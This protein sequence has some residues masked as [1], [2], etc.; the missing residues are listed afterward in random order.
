M[1]TEIDNFIKDL[2]TI[3]PKS[4]EENIKNSIE[5]LINWINKYKPNPGYGKDYRMVV[6]DYKSWIKPYIEQLFLE[7][8]TE[9]QFQ[10]TKKQYNDIINKVIVLNSFLKKKFNY[11]EITSGQISIPDIY[12]SSLPLRD[13]LG[14]YINEH[15]NWNNSGS[16]YYEMKNKI[17]PA[18][19][20]WYRCLLN[21]YTSRYPQLLPDLDTY[22]VTHGGKKVKKSKKNK[23][24][25]K[26]KKSKKNIKNLKI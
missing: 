10:N 12:V 15:S 21:I 4:K 23:K 19:I 6:P 16:K 2:E 14:T 25:K 26:S 1:T 17:I 7:N 8:R 5:C 11:D 22:I 20:E 18:T 24:S 9:S 13:I 3:Q